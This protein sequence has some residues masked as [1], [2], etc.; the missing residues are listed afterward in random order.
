MPLDIWNPESHN[1]DVNCFTW[2]LNANKGAFLISAKC[3]L[4]Q[5]SRLFRRQ[6]LPP[7]PSSLTSMNAER[8][9]GGPWVVEDIWKS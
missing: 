8:I 9:I 4:Q 6:M 1:R 5:I 2:N 7:P 3:Y